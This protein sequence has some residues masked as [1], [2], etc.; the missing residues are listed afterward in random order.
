[1]KNI[2]I[3]VIISHFF[4]VSCGN[5][6]AKSGVNSFNQGIYLLSEFKNN[7]ASCLIPKENLINNR[8]LKY[9][10]LKSVKVNDK[11]ILN[12]SFCLEPGDCKLLAKKL[13]DGKLIADSNSGLSFNFSNGNDNVGFSANEY[14]LGKANQLNQCG[15]KYSHTLLKFGGSFTAEIT[16]KSHEI[17]AYS[18]QSS[19]KTCDPKE[20]ASK[21]GDCKSIQY[22]KAKMVSSF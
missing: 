19:K 14:S 4:L 8:A 10:I 7:D 18:P 16:N 15:G 1:M 17:L 21:K 5:E 20:A 3:L 13:E 2:L 9:F 11:G 12:L 6:V 22:Y